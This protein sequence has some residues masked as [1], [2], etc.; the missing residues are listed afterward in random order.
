MT[1]SEDEDFT[2][3]DD[4]NQGNNLPEGFGDDIGKGTFGDY[5]EKEKQKE[6]E[7]QEEMNSPEA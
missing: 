1:N 2:E 3:D 5:L 7:K 6:K 4:D